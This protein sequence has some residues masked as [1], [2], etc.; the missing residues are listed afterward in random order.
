LI[1][2]GRCRPTPP[3]INEPNLGNGNPSGADVLAGTALEQSEIAPLLAFLA[4]I[5][6]TA[7]GRL[8]ANF[9]WSSANAALHH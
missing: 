9:S 8:P 7:P 3:C 6:E 2:A 5:S 4:E 1:K